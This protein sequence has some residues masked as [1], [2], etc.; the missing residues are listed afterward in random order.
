MRPIDFRVTVN[1]TKQ[2]AHYT[3]SGA[4]LLSTLGVVAS[5]AALSAGHQTLQS[6][7]VSV[8]GLLGTV[9]LGEKPQERGILNDP[10]KY[11]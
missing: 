3:L 1:R 10:S 11:S 7:I 6:G 4:T 2:V 9:V 5:G 8:F